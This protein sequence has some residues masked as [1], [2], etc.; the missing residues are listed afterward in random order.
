MRK[1]H[2]ALCLPFL[3]C[4][5][6]AFAET[7]EPQTW[8]P[9]QEHYLGK[10]AACETGEYTTSEG[11][12]AVVRYE[13]LGPEGDS[14]RLEFTYLHNPNPQ[15]AE[16]PLSFLVDPSAADLESEVK[17]QLR[18]CLEGGGPEGSC[19]GELYQV[20]GGPS[21]S[22]AQKASTEG[23]LPCGQPVEA[24]GEPLY[25]MPRDGKWGYVDWDGNWVIEPQW[26]QADDFSEGRAAVGTGQRWGIIDRS[27]NH[28]LE[29]T[30]ENPSYTTVGDVRISSSPFELFSEGCAAAEIFTSEPEYLFVDRDGGLHR[31]SLPNGEELAGLG[32]FSEGLAW[33][34]WSEDL[35]WHYGWLDSQGEVAIPAEFADAGNFV[36]GLAPA[37]SQRGGAG[38][39]DPTGRL[40]LPRKWTLESAR[41]FSEGLA[42]V[43]IEAFTTLYMDLEDFAIEKVHD[44]ETGQEAEIEMGGA[45]HSGRA[46][47]KAKLSED[48]PSVLAFID[49]QGQVAFVPERL[50]NLAP[51]HNVRL[52]EF[53]NGLLR[54][55]VADDEESCGEGAFGLGLPSYPDAHYVYLDPEGQVVLRQ[56][57]SSE[58][59]GG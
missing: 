36:D 1:K 45:F 48:G 23:P 40:V 8:H 58:N 4:T 28:V 41:S 32:N 12:G 30:Y 7:E 35:E 56:Q 44:P 3:V 15:L 51:C 53:H 34:S 50:P 2:L 31:P 54:L 18:A 5:T 43:S 52:P 13:V 59:Q 42:P 17:N 47:V 24:E 38:F 14:C 33:F 29:T 49:T 39:I 37:E 9:T 25:P 55:L 21:A 10:V 46:P 20:L 11:T 16:K 6:A 27:G 57:K 26:E 22:A 19:Q